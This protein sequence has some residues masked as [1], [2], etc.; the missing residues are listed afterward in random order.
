MSM[1]RKSPWRPGRSSNT[2]D[3]QPPKYL[4][5]DPVR[6][7]DGR[8]GI[9]GHSRRDDLVHV[10]FKDGGHDFIHQDDLSFDTGFDPVRRR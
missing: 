3:V 6:T 2:A 10:A 5:G 7:A 4:A 8:Q 9:V 1:R